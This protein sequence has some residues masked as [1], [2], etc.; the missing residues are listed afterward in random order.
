M[1]RI[2]SAF[3]VIGALAVAPTALAYV[4]SS[5]TQNSI[6]GN[7]TFGSPT[8]TFRMSFRASRTDQNAVGNAQ[9]YGSDAQHHLH[10][11]TGF[12]SCMAV[13]ST[14]TNATVLIK[15]SDT[16]NEPSNLYGVL[17]NVTDGASGAG[18][19]DGTGDAIG[20][21]NLNQN[22]YNA[23]LSAGCTAAPGATPLS[24]G[25]ITVIKAG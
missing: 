24:S 5:A 10:S 22:Q 13:N 8:N 1:K 20:L 6:S 9:V 12:V 18:S 25:N 17:I 7:G 2:V 16:I 15:I 14:G 11:F 4:D 19:E 23:A 21:T 3:V